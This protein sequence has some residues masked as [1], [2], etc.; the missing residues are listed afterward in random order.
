MVKRI[1]DGEAT[2]EEVK[3]VNRTEYDERLAP[4]PVW[5]TPTIIPHFTEMELVTGWDTQGNVSVGT[6]T[7]H[8]IYGTMGSEL[9]LTSGDGT[10]SKATLLTNI[11][12]GTLLNHYVIWGTNP[13]ANAKESVGF[14]DPD[15]LDCLCFQI[16]G[17]KF[18]AVTKNI[19][20]EERTE[21][22]WNND[23]SANWHRFEIIWLP[24]EVIFL[25]DGTEVARHTERIPEGPA[26]LRYLNNDN[27]GA[28]TTLRI[29][30]G[31]E[32]ERF[33]DPSIYAGPFDVTWYPDFDAELSSD[34][35][36]YSPEVD[37]T[38]ANTNVEVLKF[39]VAPIGTK[40]KIIWAY[41]NL[42][43]EFRAVTSGTADIIWKWQARNLGAS[44]W[45]DLHSAVTETDIGTSYVSRVRK[46]YIN[47]QSDL[48]SV[49]FEVRLIMQCNEA[50]EGR[51][52]VRNTT[53]VRVVYR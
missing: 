35:V 13:Q 16:L 3:V 45:Q 29:K 41:A 25:I 32:V 10:L 36:Q 17:T 42:E 51:A 44:T 48:D 53:F 12:Y 38:T 11:H 1:R 18:Y 47:L 4:F 39:T 24:D 26:G 28:T 8:D 22:T 31:L 5:R 15:W 7:A 30:Q 2:V 19:F 6:E 46:G 40:R 23:Y 34:G 37:T 27:V 14:D 9:K 52:R 20:G 50:N 49:P 33:L 43:A 21:L